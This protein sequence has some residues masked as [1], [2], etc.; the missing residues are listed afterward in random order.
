MDSLVSSSS[1]L[2]LHLA[3]PKFERKRRAQLAQS[4][5]GHRRRG[6]ESTF[7]LSWPVFCSLFGHLALISIAHLPLVMQ[8][9]RL[10]LWVNLCLKTHH[11]FG[12]TKYIKQ[13][14]PDEGTRGEKA[15]A[16]K[17]ER[18]RQFT[19]RV[20]RTVYHTLS[21]KRNSSFS[22]AIL[23]F[24]SQAT[25]TYSFSLSLSFFCSSHRQRMQWRT[26]DAFDCICL[27]H[28]IQ[29]TSAC[30]SNLSL[31]VF[32]SLPSWMCAARTTEW[33]N[34]SFVASVPLFW[35]TVG[36]VMLFLR[37]TE[38][39]SHWLHILS[40]TLSLCPVLTLAISFHNTA[41][42][43]SIAEQNKW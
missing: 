42:L 22:K 15:R 24:S 27:C 19:R 33:G 2:N 7:T 37:A 35:P 23:F 6:R 17:R 14:P 18:E 13:N 43:W 26:Y 11:N 25:Y 34:G 38:S 28:N 4:S 41:V 5:S 32:L 30:H 9:T 29:H 39:L 10:Q 1:L 3:T 21:I 31:S 36:A 40:F 20:T 16:R 8:V 12:H